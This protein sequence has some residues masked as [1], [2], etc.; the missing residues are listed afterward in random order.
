MR[1]PTRPPWISAD[2]FSTLLDALWYENEHETYGHNEARTEPGSLQRQTW[3]SLVARGWGIRTKVEGTYA[4]SQAGKTALRA[5]GWLTGEDPDLDMDAAVVARQ[6]PG[7]ITLSVHDPLNLDA[8]IDE[9]G[10]AAAHEE[11]A[12]ID[13]AQIAAWLRELK[14]LTPLLPP[15]WKREQREVDGVY[16]WF[17]PQGQLAVSTM[18]G[19]GM[20]STT[21]VDTP[22]SVMIDAM[23]I[24]GFP[25]WPV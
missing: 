9:A 13:P 18:P 22:A 1:K 20:A 17:D 2:D 12:K 14:A 11:P 4:V 15:G 6:R 19:S 3:E 23:R 16:C 7:D 25:T 21:G 10:R 24:A 5:L 8:A